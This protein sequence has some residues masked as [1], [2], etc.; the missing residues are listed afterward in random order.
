MPKNLLDQVKELEELFTVDKAK[1]KEIVAHF[2]NELQ[3][4]EGERPVAVRLP[5]VYLLFF[6]RFHADLGREENRSERG[7][8]EYRK[9]PLPNSVL[10]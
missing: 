5:L 8:R 2:V 6:K 10:F 3:K 4:G 7:R 9:R 1:L